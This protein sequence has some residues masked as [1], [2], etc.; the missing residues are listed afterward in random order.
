MK[1]LIR[2]IIKESIDEFDWVDTDTTNLSGQKLY[3]MIQQLFNYQKTNFYI[4]RTSYDDIEIWDSRGT[5]ISIE[6]SGFNIHNIKSAVISSLKNPNDFEIR[7]IML[8]LALVLE[9]II[10]TISL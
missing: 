7:D 5:Y 6:E 8:E 1:N 3:E 4:S 10:G 9:P 2:R